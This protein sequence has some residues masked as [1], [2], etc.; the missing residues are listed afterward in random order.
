MQIPQGYKQTEIGVIPEDWKVRK[1]EDFTS[2]VTGATPSTLIKEYWGGDIPWMA[3]G[4][5]NY[6]IVDNVQGRI[7]DAGYKSASTHMIPS[8]CVLIGLAGQGKTR[9]TAAYNTI[10]LCTNQ[11]IA[12][13]L[14][15]KTFVSKYLYY[16]LDSQYD[17]LRL[18]SS[19][20]GGR[21]GLNLKLIYNLQVPF[22]PINEQERI[23]NALTEIDE[24]IAGLGEQIKK[25]RQI[26]EGAMQQLFSG[27]KRLK[28]FA[29]STYYKNTE[30]GEIPE[31]WEVK[32]IRDVGRLITESV[33]PQSF[34]NDCFY[35]YSMP[36]FD[37]GK[38]PLNTEGKNM[39]SN[40]TVICAPV[41]LFNKLNVRQKRIWLVNECEPN[42]ICSMEFLPYI[43]SKLD[44]KYLRYLVETN[45]ITNLFIG[46]SKGTSNSQ[47]R[48]SPS[49]FL[50]LEIP[51]PSIAEQTAIAQ[52]LSDMDDE[53]S[54]LEEERDKYSLIKQG[55]MQELLTGKIRLV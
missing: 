22:P 35:E 43:S 30:V 20:D 6:K 1:I 39:H 34:P 41:L 23:A 7:T 54:T 44:L 42:S 25:K 37:E 4:E 15:Q 53:I 14:P 12:S 32:R 17:Y 51:F 33:N 50:D 49:D 29:K 11:S 46:L 28:E 55:M 19:G 31:D 5:L 18:L 2:V 3:S 36:S 27:K 16:Y 52:F 45:K 8:Y 9:G 47:K 10:P 26:K 21:G 48:I 24:L 13:I 38:K 40:R